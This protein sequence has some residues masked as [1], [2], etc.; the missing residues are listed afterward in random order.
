[1]QFKYWD[2]GDSETL[3]KSNI[4][5]TKKCT[6]LQ[7]YTVNSRA[8]YIVSPKLTQVQVT[9]ACRYNN[10]VPLCSLEALPSFKKFQNFDLHIH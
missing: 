3:S 2:N 4:F 5:H 7:S 8:P 10:T 6:T 9:W 1:M